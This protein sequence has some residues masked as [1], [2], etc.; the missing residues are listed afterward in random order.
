MH[1][2]GTWISVG[3]ASVHNSLERL[4]F[5]DA[6]EGLRDERGCLKRL[7]GD[8]LA[9]LHRHHLRGRYWRG[10][11]GCGLVVVGSGAGH[12]FHPHCWGARARW[13]NDAL[14]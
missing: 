2:I 4:K 5:E 6:H 12:A 7:Q 14:R 9:L 8:S 3:G 11:D 13:R 10:W 1:K